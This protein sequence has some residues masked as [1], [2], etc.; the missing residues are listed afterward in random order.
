MSQQG[1]MKQ[2]DVDKLKSSEEQ[3]NAPV[4]NEEPKNLRPQLHPFSQEQL[5]ASFKERLHP[6]ILPS[7][8]DDEEY[9]DEEWSE[10]MLFIVSICAIFVAIIFILIK[11]PTV[12]PTK[13]TVRHFEKNYEICKPEMFM[14]IKIEDENLQNKDVIKN[15]CTKYFSD[16]EEEVEKGKESIEECLAFLPMCVDFQNLEN[17]KTLFERMAPK[18]KQETEEREPLTIPELDESDGNY[19]WKEFWNAKTNFFSMKGEMELVKSNDISKKESMKIPQVIITKKTEED[20]VA[21]VKKAVE[22]LMKIKQVKKA[23]KSS[24]KDNDN[25][26]FL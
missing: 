9:A 24:V 17:A 13:F 8:D 15:F 11:A 10:I 22:H 6:K 5:H 21:Y 20:L 7:E 26:E 18:K 12:I 25:A 16:K 1:T 2:P 3:V 14:L 23:I 4:P 19:L